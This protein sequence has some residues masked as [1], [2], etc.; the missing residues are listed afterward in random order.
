VS[1][2]SATGPMQCNA[3]QCSAAQRSALLCHLCADR[4]SLGDH[5]RLL[6]YCAIYS[7]GPQLACVRARPFASLTLLRVENHDQFE[8][9]RRKKDMQISVGG[10]ISYLPARFLMNYS[11][12]PF[13]RSSGRLSAGEFGAP[14][15][16]EGWRL[17]GEAGKEASNWRPAWLER[18]QAARSARRQPSRPIE[19]S[20]PT[21][22]LAQQTIGARVAKLLAR[23]IQNY[24]VNVRSKLAP[25]RSAN[26]SPQLA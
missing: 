3:M 15:E 8:R 16:A 21:R 6:I 4:T 26:K 22:W 13:A 20:E 10:N 5:Q 12:S 1:A 2:I 7:P 14:G 24:R 18:G 11:A 19:P 9:R 17:R 25:P 23:F